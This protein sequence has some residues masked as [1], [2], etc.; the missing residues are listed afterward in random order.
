MAQ[1]PMVFIPVQPK[2]AGLP[3][4]HSKAAGQQPIAKEPSA[5]SSSKAPSQGP[6]AAGQQP[7]AKEPSAASSSKAPSQGPSAAG[8]QPLAEEPQDWLPDL[9]D[10]LRV[11]SVA[12]L[13]ERFNDIV[14]V[15]TIGGVA[16]SSSEGSD[17]EDELLDTAAQE[18]REEPHIAQ[19]LRPRIKLIDIP[20]ETD[21]PRIKLIEAPP[22][23][24]QRITPCPEAAASH[25]IEVK[26][27]PSDDD[28][29]DC[30]IPAGLM[31]MFTFYRLS[32]YLDVAGAFVREVKGHRLIS[33]PLLNMRKAQ[34]KDSRKGIYREFWY[35]LNNW[36]WLLVIL[37]CGFLI[38]SW[39]KDRNA[40]GKGYLRYIWGGTFTRALTYA[41][42]HLFGKM[43]VQLYFSAFSFDAVNHKPGCKNGE[44]VWTML[45]PESV[46][47]THMNIEMCDPPRGEQRGCDS[48]TKPPDVFVEVDDTTGQDGNLYGEW[49]DDVPLPELDTLIHHCISIHLRKKSHQ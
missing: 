45:D 43:W 48:K 40:G 42:R 34:Q 25:Y 26:S 33:I 35:G 24:R 16:L 23:K 36:R 8:Q 1:G 37:Q 39:H 38:R 18:S 9:A 7:L 15:G 10:V 49:Q 47:L 27:E 44:K 14:G 5:A 11:P 21:P 2:A 13:K 12:A 28:G 22:K 3:G 31:N 6:S 17:T 32:T 29:P 4:L 19:E 46:E 20:E 41:R 30:I